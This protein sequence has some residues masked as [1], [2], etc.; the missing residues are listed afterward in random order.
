MHHGVPLQGQT[1]VGANTSRPRGYSDDLR[2]CRHCRYSLDWRSQHRRVAT[3]EVALRA[4]SGQQPSV[5]VLYKGSVNRLRPLLLNVKQSKCSSWTLAKARG[6]LTLRG[7]TESPREVARLT[8][9]TLG[10]LEHPEKEPR[11]A[12]QAMLFGAINDRMSFGNITERARVMQS[13][14]QRVG[15]RIGNVGL[16]TTVGCLIVESVV[17]GSHTGPLTQSQSPRHQSAS[18]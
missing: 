10:V 17:S 3:D 13:L 6:W 7:S 14:E 2:D 15:V 16:K 4:H 8:I 1:T 5:E 12:Q 11:L 9:D 18:T